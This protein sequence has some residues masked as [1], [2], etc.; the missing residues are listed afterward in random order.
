[1]RGFIGSEKVDRTVRQSLC[2]EVGL[3]N[4]H[5]HSIRA[6]DERNNLSERNQA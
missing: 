4:G 5:M 6:Q 2:L 1:M 3:Y